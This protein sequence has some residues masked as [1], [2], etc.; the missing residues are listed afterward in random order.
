[1]W[2]YS[3]I[4]QPEPLLG[5]ANEVESISYCFI[6]Q[7]DSQRNRPRYSA[8]PDVVQQ[9]LLLEFGLPVA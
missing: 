2:R 4:H 9:R 5:K 6:R 7:P 8:K 1:M 3:V